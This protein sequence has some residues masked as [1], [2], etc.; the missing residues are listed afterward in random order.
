MPAIFINGEGIG[1]FT[2]GF[3]VNDA[4]EEQSSS[5]VPGSSESPQCDLRRMGAPGLQAMH[6]SGELQTLISSRI[7]P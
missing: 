4:S 3:E 2:D 1:G 7:R 6:E 5:A